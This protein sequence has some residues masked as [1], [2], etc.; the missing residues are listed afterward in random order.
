MNK[1]KK[2]ENLDEILNDL[3]FQEKLFLIAKE[4]KI[5]E[6]DIKSDAKKILEK[7]Y[8]THDKIYDILFINIFKILIESGFDKKININHD[9]IIKIINLMK[10]GSVAFV[11]SHKSY[12]DLIILFIIFGKYEL[13]LPFIFSGIN[14]NLPILGDIVKKSGIIFIKRNIK[15]DDVY[16]LVLR[17]FTKYL[18]EKKKHFVWAIEGTRSRTG[19]LYPAKFGI[20]KYLYEENVTFVPV[21]IIYDI[22][23]DLDE[24]YK[25][26]KGKSKKKET[27]EWM[28][29][30]FKSISSYNRGKIYINFDINCENNG[31]N[32]EQFSEKI[33][34]SINKITPITTVSLICN[35]LLNKISCDEKTLKTCVENIVIISKCENNIDSKLPLN[36]NV[37]KALLFLI[38]E[39]IIKNCNNIY[40]INQNK[41]FNALYYSNMSANF[42]YHIAFIEI[43][44]FKIKDV[45]IKDRESQFWKEVSFL[46]KIFRLEFYYDDLEEN[47]RKNLP[48]DIFN[49]DIESYL[50]NRIIL[51]SPSILNNILDSYKIIFE[52]LVNIYPNTDISENVFMKNCLFKAEELNWQR[53]SL[54]ILTPFL[55]NGI[56]LI[57]TLNIEN[58][59]NL[60]NYKNKINKIRKIVKELSKIN[61][62]KKHYEYQEI[63]KPTS[64]THDILNGEKGGHIGAFF[65]LDKTIIQGFSVINFVKK[66]ILSGKV[67]SKEAVNQFI[68][69][70]KYMYKDNKFEEMLLDTI[71]SLKG[72][73]EKEFIELGEEIS[74]ELKIYDE[75]IE[76][77]NAHFLMGHTVSIISSATIY[78][79]KPIAEKLDI[80]I[81]KCN[82]FKVNEGKF[83]GEIEGPICWGEGKADA[84]RELSKKYSL[85]LNKS[86]FYTDSYKDLP[87]LEIVGNPRPINPDPELVNISLKKNWNVKIYGGEQDSDLENI[88]RSIISYFMVI[89]GILKSF[90]TGGKIDE[91]MNTMADTINNICGI[92]LKIKNEEIV[93]KN[94]PSIFIFNHQSYLDMLVAI[95]VIKKD[96]VGIGKKEIK[97]YPIIGKL[98]EYADTIFIDRQ[99]TE[100]SK[101]SLAKITEIVKKG[102]SIVFF[103][104]GTR[105]FDHKLGEF[106][107]GIF[108]IAM[109][110][111]LNIVPIVIKNSH[112][113]MPKGSN[114][115]NPGIIDIT[116]LNA[117]STENW[118]NDNLNE[119]IKD[120]RTLFLKELGQ[121]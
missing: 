41:Y 77:I 7:L 92:Y 79:V 104:E 55:E 65:D 13:S 91:I 112:D 33:M 68:G 90:S 75:S 48:D 101:K 62:T 66:R 98:L 14:L 45:E 96:M 20:L 83:T 119:K 71:S 6:N 32:L 59:K 29:D 61:F 56:G 100:E 105:S 19:K 18:I 84:A 94:R 95:K 69:I 38:K 88:S 81:I 17:Y 47:I 58:E 39:D 120:V 25:E 28:L 85:V 4:K 12:L 118:N 44:L 52:T 23:P 99:N 26:V 107:K 3:E 114:I 50:N 10:K 113:I 115:I 31:E 57:K 108:Y 8:S 102:K 27:F 121:Y 46:K 34:L 22:I 106:K 116:I 64:L 70:V 97:S 2:K 21:S 42:F 80:K 87:L 40:I 35:V 103:P 30:Y 49:K 43:S 73:E 51:I 74:N 89:P 60:H 16:R 117:I 24:I 93:E 11:C 72:V 111:K 63:Y 86:Y 67:T 15:D 9:E 37:D 82:L 109:E 53:K 36:K 78:Q 110:N 1:D 54:E 5:N 76:L